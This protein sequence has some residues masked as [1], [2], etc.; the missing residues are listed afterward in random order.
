MIVVFGLEPRSAVIAY[1]LTKLRGAKP[2]LFDRE[3]RYYF[4]EVMDARQM[5]FDDTYRDFRERFGKLDFVEDRKLYEIIS[6][7]IFWGLRFKAIDT[8]ALM[9]RVLGLMHEKG[10]KEYLSESLPEAREM[11]FRV[12]RV[13]AEYNRAVRFIRFTRYG[14]LRLSL[15]RASFEN[16]LVDMVLRAEA[17]RNPPGTTVAIFD[18]RS[19][20]ILVNGQ[21]YVGKR[22]RIP[23][24]PEK[25]EF[26][27]FWGGLPDS[28]KRL[29]ALDEEHSIKEIP[30]IP[31][32]KAE[33]L[34]AQ[35]KKGVAS[36]D[37]FAL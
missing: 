6:N 30:E 21:P 26:E 3:K 4:D 24:V 13:L 10:S 14:N 36:L 19:V 23:L 32:Q 18:D 1:M 12:K 17:G 33:N 16:D 8:P 11:R 2:A 28:G 5:N 35:Q 34:E 37:D 22:Q 7:D 20:A 15:A 31:A 27:H 25:K 29:L 9:M